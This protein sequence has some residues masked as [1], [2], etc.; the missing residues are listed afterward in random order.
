MTLKNRVVEDK[1][2]VIYIS[3]YGRSGSTLLD[4]ILGNH[5]KVIST[6]ELANVV[7]FGVL[8]NHV[9]NH[10]GQFSENKF[11][12]AVLADLEGRLPIIDW[13]YIL[14]L[15]EKYCTP[16][17]GNYFFSLFPKGERCELT[18]FYAELLISIRSVSECNFIIDSSKSPVR[19]NLLKSSKNI[20]VFN[21]FLI[22][23]LRGICAS[24]SRK[25]SANMA[26]GIPYDIPAITPR[27]TIAK[28]FLINIAAIFVSYQIPKRLK[29]RISYEDLIDHPKAIIENVTEQL[30]IPFDQKFDD[31]LVNN[32]FEVSETIVS[33]NRLRMQPSVKIQ[34][35]ATD[36]GSFSVVDRI[37]IGLASTFVKALSRFTV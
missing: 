8:G 12:M 20:S 35:G 21:I 18:N 24:L 3:G 14:R 32:E 7:S 37:L 36:V 4:I 11:W 17:V 16:T 25:W 27:H 5:P 28:W 13:G 30:C 33:G 1:P 2:Q 10:S 22:K 34:R 19:L 9:I 26:R 29:T 23:D 31:A 15:E 6:G